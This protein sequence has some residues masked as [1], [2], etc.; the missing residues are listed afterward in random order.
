MVTKGKAVAQC[1]FFDTGTTDI[2]AN[3]F[4]GSSFR[5]ARRPLHVQAFSHG[6]QPIARG[7]FFTE[8]RE[9]INYNG[10]RV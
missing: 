9:T 2:F 10:L 6:L 4:S 7:S 1:T 8:V 3:A 5:L